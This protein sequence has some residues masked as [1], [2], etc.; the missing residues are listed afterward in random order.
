M[1]DS[2]VRI[3]H[4]PTGIVVSM[5]EERS[6]I[7]VRDVTSPRVQRTVRCPQPR[8]ACCPIPSCL[9]V[10]LGCRHFSDP[11]EHQVHVTQ[12]LSKVVGNRTDLV[13]I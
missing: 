9:P 5:Q 3:T 11:R 4:A 13:E 8:T 12:G 2:A 7:K 1:T 6:Q 10:F